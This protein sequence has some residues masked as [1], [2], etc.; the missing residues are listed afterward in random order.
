M[1]PTPIEVHLKESSGTL[2]ITWSDNQVD[3]FALTYLRGWCPCAG[4]QGHFNAKKIFVDV[5]GVGLKN[6]EPV[7]SYGMRLSWSDGHTTG[8]YSFEYLRLLSEGAPD[9][10]PSNEV[11]LAKNA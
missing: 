4:C 9:E 1:Q 5:P 10:G 8:I 6:V 2:E 7:G 11:C 3:L